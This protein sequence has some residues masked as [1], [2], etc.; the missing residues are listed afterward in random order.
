[1]RPNLLKS[2]KMKMSLMLLLAVA[3]VQ[4]GWSQQTYTVSGTI[5]TEHGTPV[6]GLEI[7]LP[8]P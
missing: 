4:L 8:V 3:V 1:M 2:L 6:P 7:T 5:T